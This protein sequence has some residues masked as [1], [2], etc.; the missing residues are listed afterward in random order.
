MQE[1]G[2]VPSS[3]AA[4][5]GTPLGVSGRRAQSYISRALQMIHTI[6][7]HANMYMYCVYTKLIKEVCVLQRAEKGAQPHVHVHV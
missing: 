6:H 1:E 4:L 2:G 5:V 3:W 7:V